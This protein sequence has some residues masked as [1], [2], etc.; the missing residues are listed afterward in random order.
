MRKLMLLTSLIC[1]A[2]T[3]AFAHA[4]HVHTYMGSVTMLHGGG[5][6]MMKTTDGHEL[7]VQTSASTRWLDADDRAAKPA[8]LAAGMRVVVKMDVDGKTAA[9]VKMATP[10]RR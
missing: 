5:A 10:P 9:S 4:G 3:S 2:A 7:T 8:D 6:F 1:F